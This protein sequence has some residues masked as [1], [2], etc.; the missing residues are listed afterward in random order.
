[1][2]LLERLIRLSG[3]SFIVPFYHLVSDNENSL[4]KY[5]YPPRK[6][7]VFKNDLNVLLKYYTPVSL[8]EFIK[9][10]SLKEQA[11]KPYFHL[12]F[13]DGLSNFHEV[14][15][16][17]LEEKKIP[18][19]VFINTDFVD[20]KALFFRYKA[21]LLIQLYETGSLE[22]KQKFHT[23]FGGKKN[24]KQLLLNID[25]KSR[26]LLDELSLK[27]GYNFDSFLKKE[28]PYLTSA[29]IQ[30]LINRGFTI[31]AHS[32]NHPLY[33]EL[34]M[35]NQVEQTKTSLAFLKSKFNLNYNAF[36]FPFNDLG[37]KETFFLEMAAEL[38][39]SFGTSGIKKDNFPTNFHRLS[40]ELADDNIETFL[41][42][43]YLKYF[44]KKPLGKNI[45]P[46]D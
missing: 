23:F 17:L 34:S 20:N 29:Q 12:T 21:S 41:N 43:E 45:M 5:L 11:K 10:I 35:V 30:D 16:P 6:I 44:L 36:S 39:I 28:K 24:I 18:A 46:R 14:V 15:A 32:K 9:L 13:D 19:T 8:K 1:M 2:N 42:K 37:V 4:A 25:F 26:Y 22:K 33:S 3:R 31:G 38:D 27:V 7:D 40:F